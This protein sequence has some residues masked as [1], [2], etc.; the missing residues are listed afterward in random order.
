MKDNSHED[1]SCDTVVSEDLSIVVNEKT[2]VAQYLE[3]Y[4][5]LTGCVRE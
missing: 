1:D 5:E 4:K 3:L 2:M